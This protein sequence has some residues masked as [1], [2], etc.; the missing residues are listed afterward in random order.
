MPLERENHGK[1]EEESVSEDDTCGGSQGKIFRQ[2]EEDIEDGKRDSACYKEPQQSYQKRCLCQIQFAVI[3]RV[4]HGWDSCKSRGY[5]WS[6][7]NVS[8]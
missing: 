6:H 8:G 7:R 2:S 3:Q 4:G 5:Q 1:K